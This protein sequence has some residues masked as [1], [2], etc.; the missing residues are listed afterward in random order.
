[1]TAL[2]HHGDERHRLAI[3]VPLDFSVESAETDQGI[4][5]R[6]RGEIDCH[7]APVLYERLREHAEAGETRSVVVDLATTTFIDSRGLTALVTAHKLLDDRGG[8]LVLSGPSEP[9]LKLLEITG[10]DKV[11]TVVPG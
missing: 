9:T 1:M 11:L 10:V 8:T 2:P 3:T 7:T 5:V 6:V 4:V